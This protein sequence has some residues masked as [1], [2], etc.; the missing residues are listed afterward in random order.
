M[1]NRY[2]DDLGVFNKQ[3]QN[4]LELLYKNG[5]FAKNSEVDKIFSKKK[6][7][8]EQKNKKNEDEGKEEI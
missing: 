4:I 6:D 5:V 1:E 2:L 8:N 7:Y 3:R